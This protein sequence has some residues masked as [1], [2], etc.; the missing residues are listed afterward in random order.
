MRTGFGAVPGPGPGVDPGKI[1]V[2]KGVVLRPTN[3]Q[4]LDST[5]AKEG[6]RVLLKANVPSSIDGL[7]GNQWGKTI[8][9]HFRTKF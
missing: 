4:P 5:E 8:A 7:G 3:M 2:Y 9:W 6:D 1:V